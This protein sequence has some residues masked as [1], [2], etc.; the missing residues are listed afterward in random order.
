MI[1]GRF[2]ALATWLYRIRAHLRNLDLRRL[3]KFDQADLDALVTLERL[4]VMQ[5]SGRMVVPNGL[6]DLM[7]QDGLEI[8][9]GAKNG[10]R[11]MWPRLHLFEL[12]SATFEDHHRVVESQLVRVARMR[13]QDGPRDE[14]GVPRWVKLKLGFEG[15]CDIGEN[16]VAMMREAGAEVRVE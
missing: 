5:L 1:G 2:S 3:D 16:I 9:A 7:G 6:L 15:S 13:A 8:E 4:E 10:S 14:H 11:V 12:Y